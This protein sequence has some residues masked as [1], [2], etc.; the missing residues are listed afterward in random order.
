MLLSAAAASDLFNRLMQRR[1][2]RV[3]LLVWPDFHFSVVGTRSA[4]QLI[5]Y[6][7]LCCRN[8]EKSS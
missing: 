5:K 4:A 7:Q 3:G 2:H 1:L 6:S 8:G